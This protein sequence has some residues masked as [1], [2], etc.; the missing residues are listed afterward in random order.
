MTRAIR[1]LTALFLGFGLLTLANGLVSTLLALRMGI[2]GFALETAGLVMSAQ[3]LGFVI[4]PFFVP[5]LIHRVGHIRLFTILSALAAAA[6]LTLP[7]Y[8]HPVLWLALRAATGFSLAGCSMILESWLNHR[9]GSDMRGRVLAVYMSVNYLAFGLGQFLLLAGAPENFKLFSIAA[10]LFALALLPVAATRIGEPDRPEPR[11]PSFRRLWHLSPLGTVGCFCAGFMGT[12]FI[13]AGPLFARARGFPTGEIAVFMGFAVIAGLVLQLP[14]GRLS[15][16]MDRRRLIAVVAFAAACAALTVGFGSLLG[17]TVAIATAA[18]Y[19]GIV[20]TLYP[21]AVAHANDVVSPRDTVTVSAGLIFCSGLGATAGPVV[22]T[23]TMR[24]LGPAGL[25]I[26]IALV[27]AALGAF[28]AWRAFVAEPVP[29]ADRTGFMPMAP[30]TPAA[31]E[32]D[33]RAT[34]PDAVVV[35]GPDDPA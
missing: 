6:T 9:T 33:P 31:V 26:T 27:A 34:P 12:A 3:A 13:A 2:E 17:A 25:F 20:Y 1:Q 5:R 21:L 18:A 15:D 35:L 14:M 7:L 10:I 8:I 16:R 30:A 23:S 11:I 29:D 22:A 19:G 24:Y 28:A 32:L 4:G